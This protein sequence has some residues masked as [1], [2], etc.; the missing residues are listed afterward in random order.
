MN[1]RTKWTMTRR[2]LESVRVKEYAPVTSCRA[3]THATPFWASGSS[4]E[5]AATGSRC[6][7]PGRNSLR[8]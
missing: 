3:F 1:L 8:R 2:R 7:R 6:G 4:E 5:R